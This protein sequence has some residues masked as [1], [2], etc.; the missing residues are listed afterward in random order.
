MSVSKN[1]KVTRGIQ[2]RV[3]L[4]HAKKQR[5]RKEQ[6]C[7]KRWCFTLS[8]YTNQDVKFIRSNLDKT[9][10]ILPRLERMLVILEHH[11]SKVLSILWDKSGFLRTRRCWAI[12]CMLRWLRG[13]IWTM[14]NTVRRTARLWWTLDSLV[15]SALTTERQISRLSM[16]VQL[17]INLQRAN[18]SSTSWTATQA[19]WRRL[20]NMHALLRRLHITRA[21]N[22]CFLWSVRHWAT[23]SL[24]QSHSEHLA[25]PMACMPW[26]SWCTQQNPQKVGH[27]AS[28]SFWTSNNAL[29][30]SCTAWFQL[31]LPFLH[32]IGAFSV[33][34]YLKWFVL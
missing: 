28:F 17:L 33:C 24:T 8:N 1:R 18:V 31:R 11:I 5:E 9:K 20:A 29:H 34:C 23:H 12:M 4:Y 10:S 26:E 16:H 30:T 13:R 21:L 3:I 7:V 2:A 25:E 15:T 6:V 27:D 19:T 14:T 22:R 32:C